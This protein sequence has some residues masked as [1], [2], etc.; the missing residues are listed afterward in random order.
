MPKNPRETTEARHACRNWTFSRIP[1]LIDYVGIH[2]FGVF[3][4]PNAFPERMKDTSLFSLTKSEETRENARKVPPKRKMK[5][6]KQNTE[7]AR[8]DRANSSVLLE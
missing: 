1:F 3:F 4:Y 8:A 6:K 7:R 2:W 5:T